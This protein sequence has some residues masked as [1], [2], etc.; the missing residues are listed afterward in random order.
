MSLSIPTYFVFKICQANLSIGL[1]A[2]SNQHTVRPAWSRSIGTKTHVGNVV[3]GMA[4]KPC[5]QTLLIQMMGNEADRTTEDK[6]TV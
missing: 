4:V 2:L 1:L 6:E 5:T 3:P